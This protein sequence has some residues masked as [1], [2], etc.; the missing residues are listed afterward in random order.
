MF[1]AIEVRASGECVPGLGSDVEVRASTRAGRVE[2]RPS[3]H[4]L[5]SLGDSKDTVQKI[6]IRGFNSKQQKRACH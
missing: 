3:G 4:R 1:W 6:L 2:N 5:S